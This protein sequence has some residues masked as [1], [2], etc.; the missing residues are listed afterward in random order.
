MKLNIGSGSQ[1]FP[2]Y[3]NVDKYDDRAEIKADVCDLKM[4]DNSI[5]EVLMSHVIEHI[6]PYLIMGVFC[7][8]RRMLIPGGKLVIEVPNI[9]I[10]F[11][12]FKDA[13][14]AKR[15]FLLNSVYC[16]M[17]TS[18]TGPPEEITSPHLWGW[19]PEMLIVH[20]Q[21]AGFTNISIKSPE[22]QLA[23]FNFRAEAV[24]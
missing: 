2:G 18:G 12:E 24:K 23:Y 10:I 9:E 22:L 8:I 21:N 17:N 11:N 20:L 19:T 5:E 7:N 4:E 1:V 14:M 3:T 13:D 15:Y 16:P 6:N